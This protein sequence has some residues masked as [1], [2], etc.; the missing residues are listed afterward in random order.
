MDQDTGRAGQAVDEQAEPEE[1]RR[2]IE[3]TREDLGDTVETLAAKSDVKK[4]A[5]AKV[6]EVKAR[7][8][9]R[10]DEAL[11]K[12]K[13]ATPDSGSAAASQVKDVARE[14][15]LPVAVGAGVLAGF[16]LGRLTGRR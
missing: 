8:S 5:K 1:I 9:E 13:Q 7:V 6:D 3:E 2:D 16:L 12:A 10:K 4:Q 11:G 15:P 14:N